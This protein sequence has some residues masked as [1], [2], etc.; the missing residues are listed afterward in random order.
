MGDATE[1]LKIQTA[2]WRLIAGASPSDALH[3][4]DR[5]IVVPLVQRLAKRTSIGLASWVL[6]PLFETFPDLVSEQS[7]ARSHQRHRFMQAS[8]V[9]WLGPIAD[10]GIDVGFE[11]IAIADNRARL[12]MMS[13]VISND[14]PPEILHSQRRAGD[15][16]DSGGVFAVLDRCK[17]V[18]GLE[19]RPLWRQY[20]VQA[21][22]HTSRSSPDAV[23]DHVGSLAA[24]KYAQSESRN[25]TVE[26]DVI[27]IQNRGRFNNAFGEF[28]HGASGSLFCRF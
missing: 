26:N 22:A 27:P 23:L 25:V 4:A 6:A 19:A 28:W 18:D 21:E 13:G 5:D 3:H 10:A 20:T 12:T 8:A 17:G 16:T 24:A 2:L 7:R 15:F 1:T 9:K 11:V 14:A